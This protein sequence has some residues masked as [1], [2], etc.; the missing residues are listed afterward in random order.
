MHAALE[1]HLLVEEHSRGAGVPC[2]GWLMYNKG[3]V[4][5]I[6]SRGLQLHVAYSSPRPAPQQK[7]AQLKHQVSLCYAWH[8]YKAV[9]TRSAQAMTFV[10]QIRLPSNLELTSEYKQLLTSAVSQKGTAGTMPIAR[11]QPLPGVSNRYE[12][13]SY[14]L[15]AG[16]RYQGSSFREIGAHKVYR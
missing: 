11:L 9:C 8:K 6:F 2:V 16:R 15:Q 7:Q 5:W 3:P 1:S 13:S 4:S 12:L 14:R 10:L